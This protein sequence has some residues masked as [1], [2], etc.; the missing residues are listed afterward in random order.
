MHTLIL[1]FDAFAPTVF[2][3]LSG[4][5]KLPYLTRYAEA[6]GYAR[7]EVANPPQS[8]VSW[9]SIATGLNPGG[10]GIF[11][12]VHR[13]P[14]TYNLT[15]SL[16]PTKRGLA[17]IQF[18]P[19]FTAHTIFD[20]AARQG[21]PATTLWWPATFPARPE[22][23]V[24]TIPGLGTPDIQGRLGVGTLFTAEGGPAADDRKT[25]V[26]RLERKGPGRY[27]A[28][29][30]G[31]V[32]QTR[33]GSQP[34]TLE[35]QLELDGNGPA[36]LTIG[37]QTVALTEGSWSP[38]LELSF[39]MGR[40]VSVRALT[41]AILS[42]VE[43]DVQLYLLPLQLHPLHPVWRYASPHGFVKEAW[44]CSG[45]FLTLGWQQD[46]TALEEGCITDDQFLDLCD[47]ILTVREGLL[48]HQ[49][50]KFHEGLLASVFDSL[51]RVQHMFWRDRPDVIEAWY[52]KLD[53]LLGRVEARLAALGQASTRIVLVSDHGFAD[54]DTKVHLNR[55]L[56]E[57]GYLVVRQ[58]D[59]TASLRSANWAQSR[60]YAVGLNS[61]YINRQGREGQG[62]V[63]AA[64]YEPLVEDLARHLL[65]WRGPD[66]HPIVRQVARRSDAFSGP[67]ADYGPDL[68]VGYSPGYRASADTGLGRWPSHSLEPNRD[69]WG[70]DHCMDARSVPGV[71]FCNQGF[72]GL[73]NLSY[74]EFPM[75]AI[76]MAPDAGKAG[77][78]P[79]QPLSAEE[80]DA[81]EE[82]LRGLG[83][84]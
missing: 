1:G 57:Q 33:R 75:L 40:F 42:R 53:S 9:T 80:A 11:D 23:L 13:D 84:L 8:E 58:D 18:V 79:A 72:G 34:S 69:H 14:A 71:L 66:D 54:F 73:S 28:L 31:P 70:A 64:E 47:W 77:P 36:R 29:L 16:L 38:V 52:V 83:Y 17:G 37:G 81:V 56:Q 63:S 44:Q 21:Y 82:R 45:P 32:R 59:S 39:K 6:G 76:G 49:L 12:F 24:R 41:R 65:A 22:S 19:P 60:A 25:P 3:R 4:Q 74:R 67:Y 68:V 20:E 26:V 15:V 78:P 7:F 30:A 48:M 5:G 51:D 61:L 46:T 10:H 27:R 2:E 35:V 55:W 62:T 50:E 43:P